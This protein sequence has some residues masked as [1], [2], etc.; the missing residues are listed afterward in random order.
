M[1]MELELASFTPHPQLVNRF[2]DCDLALG[3]FCQNFDLLLILKHL[4]DCVDQVLEGHIIKSDILGHVEEVGQPTP[5][6]LLER[7]TSAE[8]DNGPGLL[9]ALD[10]LRQELSHD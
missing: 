10:L 3:P 8:L 7:L 9:V 6:L 4:R 1:L 2:A 5:V